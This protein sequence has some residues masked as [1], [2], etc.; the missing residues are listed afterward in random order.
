MAWFV[1]WRLRTN[2]SGERKS[3]SFKDIVLILLSSS[4]TILWELPS[5]PQSHTKRMAKSPPTPDM[6]FMSL[7]IR[8]DVSPNLFSDNPLNRDR[9]LYFLLQAKW[10]EITWWEPCLLSNKKGNKTRSETGIADYWLSIRT[11]PTSTLCQ[12]N[13]FWGSYSITGSQTGLDLL[14]QFSP[15]S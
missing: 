8:K 6:P 11:L 10:G 13:L 9:A 1:I 12:G 4:A 5:G 14:Y 7:Q 15:I 3:E 2:E